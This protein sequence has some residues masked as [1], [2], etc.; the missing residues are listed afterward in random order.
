MGGQKIPD[1]TNAKVSQF[2]KALAESGLRR[3]RR[4]GNHSHRR[5]QNT[6]GS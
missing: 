4:S 6:N 2:R 3:K 5:K 1:A